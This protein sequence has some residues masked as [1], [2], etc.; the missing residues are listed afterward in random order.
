M[1]VMI[2]IN[3]NMLARWSNFIYTRYVIRASILTSIFIKRII[4]ESCVSISMPHQDE[5]KALVSTGDDRG[6]YWFLLNSRLVFY[7]IYTFFQ[8]FHVCFLPFQISLLSKTM[9]FTIFV[10]FPLLSN[11]EGYYQPRSKLY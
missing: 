4:I 7:I 9:F 1:R 11:V 8:T 5:S 10:F 2:N 6:L 3:V